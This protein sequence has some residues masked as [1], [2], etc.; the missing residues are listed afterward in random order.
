M[1]QPVPFRV[2]APA[3]E[4]GVDLVVGDDRHPMTPAEGGW[5]QVELDVPADTGYRFSVDGGLAV[6]DPRAQRLP[7]GPHGDAHRI[8]TSF[9]W[10]DSGWAGRELAG[11]I[12]YEL[13][14]GTFTDAGTLDS[15]IERL[16]D[17]VALGVTTVELMPLNTFPGHHNW[18]YDGVGMY[19]VQESYGGPAA[20]ARFVDAAHGL[21]LA[22]L[23]DVVHNH[24]GPD[25]NYLAL[26]GPYFTA[27][28]HTPW[29]AAINLDG[30]ASDEVRAYLLDNVRWWLTTFRLDGLR[31]DAVHALMDDQA[32]PILEEMAQVGDAVAAE[33]GF[34]VTLVAEDD[35]N[36]Y[37]L[38]TPRSEGGIGI[39]GQ[40]ADDIHHALHVAI[41]GETDG[42]YADFADPAALPKVLEGAFYHA[43]TYSSFRRRRHGRPLD[44]RT[45]PGWRFVAS[46]QTHDQVGNRREGDRIAQ[47]ASVPRVAA[48]AALLLT[49]PFTPMLFMGE[50]WAASTPWQFFTDHTDPKLAEAVRLG[51]AAEFA[52]HGW[53]PDAVPDPQDPATF[54]GS[55]LRWDERGEGDHARMLRWYTDLIALRRATADLHDAD[56][57]RV[58]VERVGAAVTVRR[59]AYLV[60]ANLGEN[61]VTVPADGEVV[62][63]WDDATTLRDGAVVVPGPGAAIVRCA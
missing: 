41:T 51:R 22:V 18:G 49:S 56:L 7:D 55:R 9:A 54:E 13:H 2:W 21:G 8:D 26:F 10:T 36:D 35:R 63:A 4:H 20:L 34:P 52:S 31:L 33:R 44:R 48:G 46:L 14:V 17:L 59:G 45:V 28:H 32:L 6:P 62:L 42:Y 57:S 43:G 47:Q 27:L 23:L 38:T 16:P 19:A 50:E 15:A 5:W 61:P 30:P 25:G 11:S 40:W 58:A 39:T 12:V 29:G 3:A 60:V 24:L 37:R 1:S 53:G